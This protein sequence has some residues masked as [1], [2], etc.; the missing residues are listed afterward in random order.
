MSKI[1]QRALGVVPLIVFFLMYPVIALP[2]SDEMTANER[3]II[4][5]NITPNA[6]PMAQS[7]QGNTCE[8]IVKSNG[9]KYPL[10]FTEKQC[11]QL[12]EGEIFQES[13]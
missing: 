1:L 11:S 5:L 3:D 6:F 9:Q 13:N 4:V 12:K 10:R 7:T 2:T 8:V